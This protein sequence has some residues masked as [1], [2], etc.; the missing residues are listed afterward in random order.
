MIEDYVK[1]LLANLP[2]LYEAAAA[3]K[4]FMVGMADPLVNQLN[5]QDRLAFPHWI[6]ALLLAYLCYYY[7]NPQEKGRWRGFIQFL[8][9]KEVYWH[10]SARADYRYLFVRYGVQAAIVTPLVLSGVLVMMAVNEGLIQLFGTRPAIDVGTGMVIAYAL[11]SLLFIDLARYWSHRLHHMIPV[12]WE[13]HKTHHSAEVLMP[14]TARRIHPVETFLMNSLIA[15]SYGAMS[16]VVLYWC[17][18]GITHEQLIGM[19][20]FLIALNAVG[21]NLRH[22]HIWLSFGRWVEHIISSPAQHQI[23]H[24]VDPK[25]YNRNYATFFS[26][27]DWVFGTLYITSPKPE[28][29]QFGIVGEDSQAYRSVYALLTLPLQRIAWRVRG[30]KRLFKPYA[31]RNY[32]AT[33]N[34]GTA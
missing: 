14:I 27:W 13:I 12:L 3:A 24:S 26:L 30:G 28:R 21:G 9:L 32:A 29:L 10:P 17:G 16:G 6:A 33:A 22:S 18:S 19:N 5:V 8:Q 34:A 11:L 15:I 23:H 1:D 25:H 20:G 2:M 31:K 7:Q 4:R